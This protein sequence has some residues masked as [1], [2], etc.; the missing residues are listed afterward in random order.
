MAQKSIKTVIGPVRLSYLHVFEPFKFNEEDTPKFSATLLIPK[1][2][3]KLI[4]QV[5]AA[6]QEAYNAAVTEVWGG[7]KPPMKNATC[8][9]DGDEPK[10]D[11]ES[12][13]EGYENKFFLNAKS[14]RQPGV[15]DKARQP[16]LDPDELYSGCWGYASIAFAGYSNNG[17]MGISCFLNNLMKTKDDAPL[18]NAVTSAAEDFADVEVED[19]DL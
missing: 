10:A 18:G 3:D 9:W 14:T 7:K 1:S 5:N 4:K 6:I 16:I 15:V 17:K 19:D 12:R 2:D 11:G 13:G 8:L